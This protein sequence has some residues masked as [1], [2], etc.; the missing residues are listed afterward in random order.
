MRPPR[1]ALMRKP[2]CVTRYIQPASEGPRHARVT[3]Y[4][5]GVAVR[6]PFGR[7]LTVTRKADA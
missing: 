1:V 2:D 7:F 3:G 4:R 6:L 5:G